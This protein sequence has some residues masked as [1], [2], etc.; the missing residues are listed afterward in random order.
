M[1]NIF[2]GQNYNKPF[3]VTYVNTA[4]FSFYLLGPIFRHWRESCADGR[5]GYFW[6]GLLTR[7]EQQKLAVFEE[8]SLSQQQQ[9]QPS[10]IARFVPKN[11]NNCLHADRINQCVKAKK[12]SLLGALTLL[13]TVERSTG[14]TWM[15]F[16]IFSSLTRVCLCLYVYLSAHVNHPSHVGHTGL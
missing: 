3:F 11:I 8:S 2:A 10:S 7:S 16:F 1:Q 14:A 9:Q 6:A 5:D 13:S 4:S 15:S 12:T